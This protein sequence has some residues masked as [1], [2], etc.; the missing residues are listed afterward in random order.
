MLLGLH[1][2]GVLSLSGPSDLFALF[3]SS[4]YMHVRAPTVKLSYSGHCPS[5][6]RLDSTN[7]SQ[8]FS[9]RKGYYIMNKPPSL[10]FV[11]AGSTRPIHHSSSPY[12]WMKRI[13]G[14]FLGTMVNIRKFFPSPLYEPCCATASLPFKAL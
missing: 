10:L 5:K 9:G 6:L 7:P 13:S 4:S 3:T 12:V 14:K 2:V 11:F 1:Q 8:I